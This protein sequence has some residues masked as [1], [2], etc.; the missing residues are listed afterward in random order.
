ME[1]KDLLIK[2]LK[3]YG[4]RPFVEDNVVMFRYQLKRLF[5]VVDDEKDNYICMFYPN[6]Y[7]VVEAEKAAALYV[8][9]KTTREIRHLKVYVDEELENISASSEFFF[10]SE[11]SLKLGVANGLELIGIIGTYIAQAMADYSKE[12]GEPDSEIEEETLFEDLSNIVE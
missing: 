8:S 1:K 7:E 11:E 12:I 5:C 2:V 4:L 3:E 10:D 6:F 9:N